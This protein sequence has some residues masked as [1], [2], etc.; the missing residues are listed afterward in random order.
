MLPP[1]CRM[2]PHDFHVNEGAA[3]GHCRPL[4]VAAMA[5]SIHR[6]EY[7]ELMALI[8]RRREELSLSQSELARRLGW[9]QQKLSYVESG[10]RRLDVLEY[11]ELAKELKWSPVKAIGAAES[12][13]RCAP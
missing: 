12:A 2:A 4:S 13:L 1:A 8:R 7:I 3:Y 11:L 10:T 6:P 9:T 5:K